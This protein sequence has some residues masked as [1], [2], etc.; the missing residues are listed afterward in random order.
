MLC[1]LAPPPTP[2]RFT[3]RARVFFPLGSVGR[4]VRGAREASKRSRVRRSQL[5][6]IPARAPRL[7]IP[8]G[9][10]TNLP[11]PLATGPL[12]SSCCT[13]SH[14]EAMPRSFIKMTLG[15]PTGVDV[16]QLKAENEQLRKQCDEMTLKLEDVQAKLAEAEGGG[17]A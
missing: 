3:T 6:P 2:E 12:S 14:R 17:E 9:M 10:Q 11:P 8:Q 1:A 13:L 7:T 5:N 15:A 4:P 16:D